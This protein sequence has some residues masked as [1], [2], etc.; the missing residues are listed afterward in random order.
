MVCHSYGKA[1]P[2]LTSVGGAPN[3]PA[4]GFAQSFGSRISQIY[5]CPHIW[6]WWKRRGSNP[7]YSAL[8]G[9]VISLFI[10]FI[11]PTD[12]LQVTSFR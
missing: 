1:E 7:A 6:L 8:P 12:S 2:C 11:A 5:Q 3:Q 10:V 9:N 4:I